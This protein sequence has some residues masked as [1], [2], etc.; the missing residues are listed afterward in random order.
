MLAI[1]ARLGFHAFEIFTGWARSAV[2]IDAQPGRIR[3]ALDTHGM[4]VSSFHLPVV[5]AADYDASLARAIRAAGFAAE[6]GAPIVLVKASDRATYVR[7]APALLD[8]ASA[9]G[10]TP[11]LQNHS[12]SPLATLDDICEALRAIG[13]NRLAAVLEVGHLHAE[14][15]FEM[16]L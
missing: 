7:A 11:V 13:D 8:A 5:E 9:L 4:R 12:G 14:T 16:C 3:Q 15:G 6:I 2:D 1:H 10:L